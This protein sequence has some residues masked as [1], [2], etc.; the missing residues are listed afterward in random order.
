MKTK[1]EGGYSE[2]RKWWSQRNHPWLFAQFRACRSISRRQDRVLTCGWVII[3]FLRIPPS[4]T[5]KCTVLMI[6]VTI[7]VSW[8]DLSSSSRSIS[9]ATISRAFSPSWLLRSS[10]VARLMQCRLLSFMKFREHRFTDRTNNDGGHSESV[11]VRQ[12]VP[13]MTREITKVKPRDTTSWMVTDIRL[14]FMVNE[15][16]RECT[17]KSFFQ[18]NSGKKAS[19]IYFVSLMFICRVRSICSDMYWRQ[20]GHG[21]WPRWGS[22]NGW[23]RIANWIVF[24]VTRERQQ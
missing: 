22:G 7:A 5:S 20:W 12:T 3:S 8:C 24:P 4:L 23:L 6:S 18:N 16:R 10:A 13:P 2:Q 19:E 11:V 1:E 14:V 15:T 17:A 9:S 21:C